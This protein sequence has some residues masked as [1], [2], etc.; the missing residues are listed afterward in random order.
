MGTLHRLCFDQI[1]FCG[2]SGKEP[3][4]LGFHNPVPSI[5]KMSPSGTLL[6]QP[7]LSPSVILVGD[8]MVPIMPERRV[9]LVAL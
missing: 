4:L 2:L 8:K 6:P 7:H 5:P 3:H 9:L 1:H